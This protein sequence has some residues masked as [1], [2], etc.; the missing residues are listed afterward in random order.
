MAKTLL[1]IEDG[2]DTIDALTLA[3]LMAATTIHSKEGN[4]VQANINVLID[5][6]RALSA[7]VREMREHLNL[8]LDQGSRRH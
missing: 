7:D 6:V 4:A 1:D 2:L 8:D 3:A 5:R